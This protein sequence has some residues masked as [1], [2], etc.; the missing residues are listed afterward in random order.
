MSGRQNMNNKGHTVVPP[1]EVDL[2][3]IADAKEAKFR[4]QIHRARS[5]QTIERVMRAIDA[6][7]LLSP[8]AV[9]DLL[10]YAKKRIA[11]VSSGMRVAKLQPQ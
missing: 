3:A 7:V 9:D 1:I 2:N 4:D 6:D 8:S 5:W 10:A 11:S